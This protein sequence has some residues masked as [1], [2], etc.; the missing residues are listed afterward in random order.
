VLKPVDTSDWKTETIDEH[1]ETVRN[2]FLG[3]LGQDVTMPVAEQTTQ[4]Q[5]ESKSDGAL[6]GGSA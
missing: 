5:D 3:C 4:K 1:V 2:L 6:S